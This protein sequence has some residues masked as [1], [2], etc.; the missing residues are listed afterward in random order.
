MA[1]PF[2]ATRQFEMFMMNHGVGPDALYGRKPVDY[3]PIN[4]YPRMGE[5]LNGG[6]T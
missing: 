6:Q 2:R 1:D 4:L 5:V 3:G